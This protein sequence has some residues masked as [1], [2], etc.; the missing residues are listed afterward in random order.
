MLYDTQWFR[1]CNLHF[2]LCTQSNVLLVV[3]NSLNVQA[4]TEAL[5]DDDLRF[6]W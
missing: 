4:L 2:F 5:T 6:R 1:L 3:G